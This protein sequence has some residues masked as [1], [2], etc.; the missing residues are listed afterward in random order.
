MHNLTRIGLNIYAIGQPK[1]LVICYFLQVFVPHWLAPYLFHCMS[2]DCCMPQH[3][4]WG[5]MAAVGRRRPPWLASVSILPCA[6]F[7]LG[8]LR[9]RCLL[10]PC[11]CPTNNHPPIHP[12]IS[13]N[14]RWMRTFYVTILCAWIIGRYLCS[15]VAQLHYLG[16]GGA[17]WSSRNDGKTCYQICRSTI[18][19]QILG[20]F[21]QTGH[22]IEAHIKT[23]TKQFLLFLIGSI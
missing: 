11:P 20:Q 19:Q 7:H 22:Q 14:N 15:M 1:K 8:T 2:A 4:E 10:T 23:D 13:T 17:R 12:I 16:V 21:W 18:T 9:V 6:T 5:T 3:R